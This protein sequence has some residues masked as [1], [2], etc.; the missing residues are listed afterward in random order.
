MLDLRLIFVAIVWG[1]NF[2]IVKFALTDFHPLSFTVVRFF[3]G[4]L[5]L[6]ALMRVNREPFG[7]ERS[8]RFPIVRL[9]LVGIALYNI[10]FMFGLKHTTASNSALIIALSPLF[11]AVIRTVKGHERL[12]RTAG[13]GIILAAAGVVLIIQGRG[14]GLGFSFRTLRGDLL[15]LCASF[16]WAL[17]TMN[18]KPLLEKYPPV[19]VTAFSMAIGSVLLLPPA[20]YDLARQSWG[21]ITL[22]AWSALGFSAIVSGGI[23]FSL[24][25][26]GVKRIGVTRT[27][28]YHYLVPFVAVIFA[29]L[30]LGERITA[31]QIIGGAAVLAGVYLVQRRKEKG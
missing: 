3:L 24:W 19:K 17:Y 27:I 15:T 13:A 12:T 14:A 23:A 9:G 7:I 30:F 20:A 31:P 4:S 21:A 22:S 26:R 28:V 1:I 16:F 10:F 25:Y 29:A 6:L 11:A 2:S 18:A 8:D 5:F